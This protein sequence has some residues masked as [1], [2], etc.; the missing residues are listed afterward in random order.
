MENIQLLKL[1]GSLITDK[2]QA[3]TARFE[4]ITRLAREIA[5]SKKNYPEIKLVL[6]HGSGSFGH[7]PGHKYATRQGVKSKEQWYGFVEVWREAARL[8]HIVADAL[9]SENLP[10]IV[11]SPLASVTSANG[12]VLKWDLYPLQ[13]A[14]RRGL[15]P[16]IYG[17]VV[18]DTHRGGTIL[19]TEDLFDYLIRQLNP[20]RVLLAGLEPGVWQDFP[21][22]KRLITEITSQ[23]F[24]QSAKNIFGSSSTDV[25]GGMLS[26]VNQS[27]HWVQNQ[28]NLEIFIFSAKEKGTL[29][30]VLSGEHAGTRIIT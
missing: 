27:I 19:S 26:K 1:G 6:G 18:F 22:C 8:N 23:D 13:S 24:E 10:I 15:I 5:K 21:V 28:P 9:A 11:F 7:I 20:Q 29:E 14:L 2:S 4:V 16:V 12:R 30:R 17:D 25:T 3:H